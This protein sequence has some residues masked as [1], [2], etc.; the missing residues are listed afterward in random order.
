MKGLLA[1]VLVRL[2]WLSK[3]ASCQYDCFFCSSLYLEAVDSLSLNLE[4]YI[5]GKRFNLGHLELTFSSAVFEENVEI[6]SYPW[7][8]RR[9]RRR[10]AK[11]LTFSN[12]SVITEDIYLKHRLVVHF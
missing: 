2:V 4:G 6:L 1:L 12:I 8:R 3:L 11:T 7:R 9:R 5:T 10:R